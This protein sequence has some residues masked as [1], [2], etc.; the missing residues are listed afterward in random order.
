MIMIMIHEKHAHA[1]GAHA[2]LCMQLGLCLAN[3]PI[4]QLLKLIN[5]EASRARRA[6]VLRAGRGT[7]CRTTR[8]SEARPGVQG[9]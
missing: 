9:R 6:L 2:L 5:V 7:R 3:W 4:G 8:T 1:R